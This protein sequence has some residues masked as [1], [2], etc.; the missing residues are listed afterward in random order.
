[1][2]GVG[3]GTSLTPAL[4]KS[5]TSSAAS[6]RGARRQA[7]STRT[8][9]SRCASALTLQLPGSTSR[10]SRPASFH[11]HMHPSPASVIH[12]SAGIRR[13]AVSFALADTWP[14]RQVSRQA[15]SKVVAVRR[16]PHGEAGVVGAA[17]VVVGGR[18]EEGRPHGLRQ[19][20]APAHLPRLQAPACLADLGKHAEP[21]SMSEA[22]SYTGAMRLPM[23]VRLESAQAC[24]QPAG[25]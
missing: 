5:A 14:F 1:M 15:A 8:L 12:L 19:Q 3:R 17:E 13:Q 6:K 7:A 21:V 22:L 4:A 24:Q 23:E 25:W 18:A 9:P 2:S 10:Q 20:R 11:L 16:A